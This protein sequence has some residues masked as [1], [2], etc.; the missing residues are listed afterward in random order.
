MTPTDPQGLQSS[1]HTALRL[2]AKALVLSA[3]AG[4]GG[5]YWGSRGQ[6]LPVDLTIL[7][8]PALCTTFAWLQI[9]ATGPRSPWA[10]PLGLWWLTTSAAGALPVYSAGT[11][12]TFALAALAY[13]AYKCGRGTLARLIVLALGAGLSYVRIRALLDAY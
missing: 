11:G 5:Y 4:V 12:L 6:H 7:P 1:K 9:S 13:A 3:C 8:L 10:V 2:H